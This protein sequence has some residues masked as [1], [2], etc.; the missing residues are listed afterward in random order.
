MSIQTQKPTA[1]ASAPPKT[2]ETNPNDNVVKASLVADK[3]EVEINVIQP[4][5]VEDLE[6]V[7]KPTRFVEVTPRRTI[8]S[9]R[10][11]PNYY[12]FVANKRLRVPSEIVP[13]LQQTGI[14]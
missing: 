11:G 3:P 8:S 12:S 5:V 10:I 13:H 14:I 4:P 9:T 6:P 2:L 7:A 1:A